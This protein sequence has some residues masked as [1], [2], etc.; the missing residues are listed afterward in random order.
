MRLRFLERKTGIA[1]KA[2]RLI[3]RGRRP[4]SRLQVGRLTGAWALPQNQFHLESDA[5][6]RF[7]RGEREGKDE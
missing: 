3:S 2:S 4:T 5:D 1:E 6:Q 7:R